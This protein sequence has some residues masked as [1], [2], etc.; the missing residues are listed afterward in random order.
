MGKASYRE[1]IALRQ[2]ESGGGQPSTGSPIDRFVRAI[3][4]QDKVAVPIVRGFRDKFRL[5]PRDRCQRAIKLKDFEECPLAG[6]TSRV[7]YLRAK[8]GELDADDFVLIFSNALQER[9]NVPAIGSF[10]GRFTPEDLSQADAP[11]F[12]LGAGQMVELD[13]WTV[14]E[15]PMK[16]FP[17][18]IL[19][20]D[21]TGRFHY[22]EESTLDDEIH[23]A[24][25]KILRYGKT[26]DQEIARI[27]DGHA[28]HGLF[29]KLKGFLYSDRNASHG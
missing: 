16:K 25:R 29:S 19:L 6:D 15:T 24:V 7:A 10:F 3:W 12:W 26:P 4:A 27:R 28:E 9:E 13:L 1:R 5:Y 20:P 14:G 2:S 22:E 8:H 21:R 23:E 17:W 18:K 11:V